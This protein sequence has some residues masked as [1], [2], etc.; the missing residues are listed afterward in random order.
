MELNIIV[1]EYS[2]N[3]TVPDD[4]LESSKASFDRLDGTMDQGVQLGQEW[5]AVPRQLQRCQAAADKLLT[6]LETNNEGLAILSA[7][8]ILSRMPEVKRVWIDNSGE[9]G[10]NR[11]E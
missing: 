9:P 5:V 11:F 3:I 7:G 1:D 2:M 6:A 8:Y 10:E 4:F